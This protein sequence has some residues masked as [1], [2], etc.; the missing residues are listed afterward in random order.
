MSGAGGVRT[1]NPSTRARAHTHR[2]RS[3]GRGKGVRSM[4]TIA[5]GA[6]DGRKSPA[7]ERQFG[8]NRRHRG[9]FLAGSTR[10]LRRFVLIFNEIRVR[11]FWARVNISLLLGLDLGLTCSGPDK[12][13]QVHT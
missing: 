2:V 9:G 3:T 12:T 5:N 13:A 8:D 4:V 6:V 1:Q 7:A 10:Y 11:S